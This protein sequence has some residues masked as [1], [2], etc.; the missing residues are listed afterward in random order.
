[1]AVCTPANIGLYD[2]RGLHYTGNPLVVL[3]LPMRRYTICP[4]SFSQKLCRMRENIPF[5]IA[6]FTGDRIF[7]VQQ[8]PYI[9][10]TGSRGFFYVM[11]VSSLL[12]VFRAADQANA[13]PYI[14]PWNAWGPDTT[15][16]LR[17]RSD[18]RLDRYVSFYIRFR[19]HVIL[20]VLNR[21]IS[22]TRI[23]WPTFDIAPN[24]NILRY[25]ILDFS[26]VPSARAGIARSEGSLASD[27]T[28]H[29]EES[30]TEAFHDGEQLIP[31]VQSRLV[32]SSATLSFDDPEAT[33]SFGDFLGSV[34]RGWYPVEL[35]EDRLTRVV[36]RG[37][38]ESGEVYV[39]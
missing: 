1:M 25:E 7:V 6:P 33:V 15:R 37:D 27:F 3:Q 30:V 26:R 38:R 21:L 35:H 11:L 39:L 24:L 34:L 2:I 23:L 4:V 20:T 10:E 16:V 9:A 8:S 5:T 36:K 28:L 13:G 14:L 29:E 19:A 18:L 12:R 22:G 32:Y 17:N 31:A